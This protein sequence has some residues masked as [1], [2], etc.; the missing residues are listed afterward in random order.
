MS[1][2]KTS[3]EQ[4]VGNRGRSNVCARKCSN[5]N[6]HVFA[7]LGKYN[8]SKTKMQNRCLTLI[9]RSYKTKGKQIPLP[10]NSIHIALQVSYNLKS[11]R[12]G[13][14]KGSLLN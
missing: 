9:H 10:N 4:A 13:K 5:D 11:N 1:S 3:K 7:F 2:K 6:D 12:T 14:A 8:T